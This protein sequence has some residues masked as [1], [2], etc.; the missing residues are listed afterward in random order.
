MFLRSALVGALT[1][2]IAVVI[3]VA[4]M[5]R[6]DYGEGSGAVFVSVSSWQILAAALVGFAA[7][8]WW[9]LR[10]ARRRHT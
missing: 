6:F 1:A 2:C 8:C 4:L 7:G 5:V 9:M 10:R 3:T